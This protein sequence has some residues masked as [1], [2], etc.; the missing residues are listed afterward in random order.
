MSEPA[1]RKRAG[2][3]LFAVLPPMLLLLSVGYLRYTAIPSA[4]F[5]PEVKDFAGW[6]H[7]AGSVRPAIRPSAALRA[8]FDHLANPLPDFHRIISFDHVFTTPQLPGERFLVFYDLGAGD[9]ALAYRCAPDG[10]LI[11]KGSLDV[12]P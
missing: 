6:V 4:E 2:C 11:S 9:A 8:K 1:R 10:K 3:F 5:P 12:S 7:G